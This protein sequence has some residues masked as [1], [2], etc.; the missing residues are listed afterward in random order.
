[1]T[2]TVVGSALGPLPY[3]MAYDWFGGYTE[4]ILATMACPV[5]GTAAAWA[6]KAPEKD[7]I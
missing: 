7:G 2:V 4:V 6:S 1:M 5:I 3:G